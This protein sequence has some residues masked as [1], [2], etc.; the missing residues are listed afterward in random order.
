MLEAIR[1][2]IIKIAVV[3]PR[4]WYSDNPSKFS[5]NLSLYIEAIANAGHEP[6]LVCRE[7]SEYQVSYP[8]LAVPAEQFEQATFWRELNLDAVLAFTGM[9]QEKM[10]RAMREAGVFVIAKGDND[11]ML[12]ARVFPRHHYQMMMS[13]AATPVQKVITFRHWVRR[14]LTLSAKTDAATIASIA[15]S[16]RASV[17]TS[18]AKT[19]L[20][21][22]L[23]YYSRQDLASRLCVLPH[24]VAEPILTAP[25]AANR[26]EKVVAIGRWDE[27]QKDTP[28]LVRTLTLYLKRRPKTQVVLIGRGGEKDLAP[29]CC[30]FPQVAALGVVPRSEIVEHLSDARI[31]LVTSRWESFHIAAHEAL[32]LGETVVGPPVVPVPDICRAGNYGTLAAGRRPEQVAEALEQEMQAWEQ[33]QRDPKQTAAFWRPRLSAETSVR[34]ML[35]MV[36]QSHPLTV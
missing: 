16:N 6:M 29:L 13:A 34:Q 12:S 15:A 36:N 10:L 1:G 9:G 21:E 18:S 25:I 8:V 35:D 14:C 2:F 32:C 17:E 31:L 30:Q 33:G 20:E 27:A 24:L 19:H 28:L 4:D 5:V 23:T 22:M 7:D 11:G 26:P 3:I